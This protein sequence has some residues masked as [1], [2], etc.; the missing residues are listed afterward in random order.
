MSSQ[1]KAEKLDFIIELR[2]I[3]CQIPCSFVL[4]EIGIPTSKKHHFL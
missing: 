4:P 3:T 2:C 1:K